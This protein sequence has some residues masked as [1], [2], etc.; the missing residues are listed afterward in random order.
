MNLTATW[1]STIAP[2]KTLLSSRG[3]ICWRRQKTRSR[4][5]TTTTPLTLPAESNT[6]NPIS[7]SGIQALGSN[8][9]RDH[10]ALIHWTHSISPTLLLDTHV[11]YT[12]DD[13]I[14]TP[15]NLVPAGFLPTVKLTVPAAFTIGNG[16]PTDLREYEWGFTEH[17]NWVKGRHSFNFGTDI[18]HDSTVSLSFSGYNG[19]YTFPSL[20]DFALG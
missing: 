9:V 12:R 16:A 19:S 13:Q 6:F 18:T 8:A 10:D 15:A 2:S 14:A 20:T 17:V 1:V 4:C 5:A 11:W 3:S 7:T